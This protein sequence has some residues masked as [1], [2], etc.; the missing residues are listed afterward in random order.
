[1]DMRELKGLEIAARCKVEFKGDAW[2]VPSQSGQGK[3]RITLSPEGDRC[4]CDDFQLRQQPCKHIHAA[5]I[6]RERDGG[7]K[8]PAID[9]A[10]VPKR[11]TYSQDWPAY[12]LAQSI[13]KHRFMELLADLCCDLTDPER[14]AKPGPKPHLTQDAVFAMTYKVY[15]GFSSRRFASDLRDAH[16][17]GYLSRPIPGPKVCAFLTNPAY[18]PL[19]TDLIVRSSLPLRAVETQFAPDSSGFSTGRFVRWYDE[20][21]GVTRSSHDWVKVHLMCGTKTHIVTAVR[22]EGRDAADC[23]QFVP[24]LQTTA[25]GFKIGEVSADKAYLSVDNVEAVAAFGGEAFIAPK[26]NTTGGVG[27]LFEKMFHYYQFNREAFLAHY[28]RRS[29]VESVFSMMK[30]KF[31]DAVRS[32]NQV[33]MKNEALCKVLCHNICVAIMSQCELGIEP[34]FW[35][36]EPV[37][38]ADVLPMVRPG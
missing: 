13:E 18:A 35:E 11:P 2:I 17:A 30:R 6:V 5:R 20:K 29:N 38:G 24:L 32:R 21:Y 23:P 9:T 33:A 36:N 27:G 14:D 1:M 25:E 34:V 10:V 4:E 19:L 8:A 7:A 22:I 15:E 12:N 28:H 37:K 31:G 26:V 16:K 3:Y